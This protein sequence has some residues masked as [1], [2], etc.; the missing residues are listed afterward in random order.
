ML[1]NKRSIRIINQNWNS[2]FKTKIECFYYSV[3][4]LSQNLSSFDASY[5]RWSLY[6]LQDEGKNINRP[7]QHPKRKVA[8]RNKPIK[9]SIIEITQFS[10]RWRK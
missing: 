8:H 7:F 5:I 3:I 10:N 9:L 4:A 1:E 6:C 2:Y